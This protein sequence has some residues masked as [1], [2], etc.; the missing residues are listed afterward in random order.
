MATSMGRS[1]ERAR[2]RVE[3]ASLKGCALHNRAV[4]YFILIRRITW[5]HWRGDVLSSMVTALG[6][7]LAFVA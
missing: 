7:P 6:W 5:A 1:T 3:A 4:I 2:L